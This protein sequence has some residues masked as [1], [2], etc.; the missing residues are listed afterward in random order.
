MIKIFI[1]GLKD[2]NYDIELK[3]PVEEVPEI[4]EEYFGNIKIKGKL[5]K[6]GKRFTFN[7]DTECSAKLICDRSLEEYIEEIYAKIEL[8]FIKKDFNNELKEED[9]VIYYNDDDKFLDITKAIREIFAISLPMKR[10]SPKYRNKSIEEIY[11]EYAKKLKES[12]IIDDR[13]EVLK[14]LKIN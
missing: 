1:Q 13:W 9:D 2:G 7:G 10:I 8:S 4:N 14:S 11:P 5:I 6:L 12:K 3:V